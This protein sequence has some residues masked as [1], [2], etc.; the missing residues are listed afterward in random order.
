MLQT[1]TKPKHPPNPLKNRARFLAV[2]AAV[3]GWEPVSAQLTVYDTASYTT[4]TLPAT[5]PLVFFTYPSSGAGL[6][7]FFRMVSIPD[8]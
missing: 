7:R 1:Q 6:K 5:G 8:N 2:L 4:E 3:I